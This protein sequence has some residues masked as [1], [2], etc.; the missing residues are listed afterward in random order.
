[1]SSLYVKAHAIC[2]GALFVPPSKSHTLRA[3]CFAFLAKGHSKIENVLCSPDT[4]AMINAIS[5]LGAKVKKEGS[6]VYVEGVAGMPRPA[7]DVIY[8]GNSGIVLRFITA[9][10]ALTSRYHVITGDPSIRFN[11]IAEPLLKGLKDLGAIALSMKEDG[12]APLIVKGPIAP[13][14]AVIDG[15][16]SQ[17][18]SA[19]LIALSFLQGESHLYVDHASEKPWIDMTLYWLDKLGIEYT[20][21]GY[22]HYHLKGR[23][24]IKGFCYTV[25][26]DYST[27]AFPLVASLIHQKPLRLFGLE[28]DDVQGDKKIIDILQEMGA[29]IFWED[30]VLC[31]MPGRS[32]LGIE[33]DAQG[34]IDAVPI[35]AAL[36]SFC[37][38]PMQIVNASMARSKES[39][40]LFAITRELRKMG[41]II[42]ETESSLT[43]Y[44]A[45]LKG[46]RVSTHHDHRIGMSLAVAATKAIGNSCV[47]E[48]EC[49]NKTYKNF[50][51][52]FQS[53]GAGMELA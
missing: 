13:G 53:I 3:L 6:T 20:A 46:A 10:C 33:V 19:L 45:G 30:N 11:R 28:K 24:C 32:L 48:I 5:M 52:D 18:V 43:I 42:E 25:P 38:K 27:A 31:S 51:K 21:D 47:E 35:L 44:P 26:G 16:D 41:A 37:T 2:E 22:E 17:P 50:I 49:I 34:C 12:K 23:A 7:D 15:H 1:M 4:D 39:D 40:R 14:R 29:D 8:V 9:L 36:G